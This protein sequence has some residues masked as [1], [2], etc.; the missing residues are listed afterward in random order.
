LRDSRGR[1]VKDDGV[2]FAFQCNVPYRLSALRTAVA[3]VYSRQVQFITV[4]R[5]DLPS[6]RPSSW[7]VDPETSCVIAE[8]VEA[9]EALAGEIPAT[10]RDSADELMRRVALGCVVCFARRKR[11]D[12]EGQE[13]VGYELAQRGIFSALGRRHFAGSDVVFSHWAEVLPAYRGRRIHG[14]LFAARDAY[15]RM[16]GVTMVVGVCA[17]KNRASLQALRRDGAV[18]VGRVKQIAVLG[19]VVWDTPWPRIKHALDVG[20]RIASADDAVDLDEL[21]LRHA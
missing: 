7:A 21:S 5:L 10:F 13:V 18:V 14:L 4:K 19:H 17:P 9:V 16:R 6:P 8:S 20:R 15:F 11:S 1:R 12:G 2:G 3:A